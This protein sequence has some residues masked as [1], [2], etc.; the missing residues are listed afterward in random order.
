MSPFVIQIGKLLAPVALMGALAA[1]MA[2]W[3]AHAQDRFKVGEVILPG[4][5]TAMMMFR[6]RMDLAGSY[7]AV[8]AFPNFHSA[9]YGMV[10]VGGTFFVG[11]SVAEWRDVPLAEMGFP[12]LNDF[13]ARMRA[14]NVYASRNGFVAAFPPTITLTTTGDRLRNRPTP[15]PRR[16]VARYPALRVGQPAAERYR[17]AVP[18]YVGLGGA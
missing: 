18:C 13:G 8:G 12:S 16:R 10:Q 9:W 5:D 4:D 2:S 1:P 14:A 17:R 11:P 3:P 6:H 7:K 15:R